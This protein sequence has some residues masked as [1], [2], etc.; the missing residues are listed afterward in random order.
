MLPREGEYL[1]FERVSNAAGSKSSTIKSSTAPSLIRTVIASPKPPPNLDAEAYYA[2]W[3]AILAVTMAVVALLTAVLAIPLLYAYLQ[4]AH[5]VT[6]DELDF[7]VARLT[8]LNNLFE[9]FQ[10]RL[11]LEG[12]T[13]HN[14]HKREDAT[15]DVRERPTSP[16]L[17]RLSRRPNQRQPKGPRVRNFGRT[18]SQ[19]Q[20]EVSAR[21]A[22]GPQALAQ[23][24]YPPQQPLS[25]IPRYNVPASHGYVTPAFPV[26]QY[27]VQPPLRPPFNPPPAP[28]MR[29]PTAQP[30]TTNV[31][32]GG[33]PRRPRPQQKQ[34]QCCGYQYGKPGPP[35]P[36][37]P[38][39]NDGLDGT[40]GK[41]GLP[42]LD[43]P[44]NS[45]PNFCYD[46]PDGPPGPAGTP[47]P[48]G[49]IGKPGKPGTPGPPGFSKAGSAGSPGAK[50]Y[51]GAPGTPGT[52]G[53]DGQLL[54]I[55]TFGPPGP[56]GPAGPRGPPGPQ[57]SPG[58]P[59]QP[60]PPGPVGPQGRDGYPG[61][62]GKPGAI[63]MNGP[64][65][66][67]SSC[68]HCATPRTPPGY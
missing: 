62:C 4:Y 60:G 22:Q 8:D 39:G 3:M 56:T 55:P 63:G 16:R 17:D 36:P 45:A 58:N 64:Q 40:P 18:R 52:P 25:H 38:D 65:G 1:A 23:Q 41:P 27:N 35:G 54:L 66:P 51:P 9:A 68:D 49:P 47:G 26:A 46:C 14:I 5:N 12:R 57:G 11:H 33:R 48:K 37:G 6:S 43:A 19:T 34:G 7:C 53:H 32:S 2:R 30:Y 42:G 15:I 20:V 24:S 50:G 61:K 10:E 59:G 31:P 28:P 67:M 21:H 29:P 44:L 13:L